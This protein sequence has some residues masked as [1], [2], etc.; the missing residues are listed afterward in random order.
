[1]DP[2]T[3]KDREAIRFLRAAEQGDTRR[4]D[5]LIAKGVPVNSRDRATGGTALHYAAAH[6]ARGT[7]RVLVKSKQCDFLI[8]DKRGRLPSELAGVYGR[9]PAMAR[10]L[11]K[12]EVQQARTQNLQLHRRADRMARPQEQMAREKSRRRRRPDRDR[13]QDRER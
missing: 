2:L 1:M 7:L 3:P 11:L 4:L 9:D 13:E 10:L 6:G 8:R 12:K 5:Q